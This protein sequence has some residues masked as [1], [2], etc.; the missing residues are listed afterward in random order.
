M[1]TSS[2]R[3]YQDHFSKGCEIIQYR[4]ICIRKITVRDEACTKAHHGLLFLER[5][6]RVAK[7]LFQWI[8]IVT[9]VVHFA[10]GF[11]ENRFVFVQ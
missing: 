3:G 11:G 5:S 4:H 10:Y 2:Y 8:G 7:E 9:E 6:K 1:P